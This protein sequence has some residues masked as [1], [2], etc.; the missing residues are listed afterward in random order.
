MA[1]K[2]LAKLIHI[3]AAGLVSEVVI[4]LVTGKTSLYLGSFLNYLLNCGNHL[5]EK[6]TL[7]MAHTYTYTHSFAI[8][9]WQMPFTFTVFLCG[10]K[11]F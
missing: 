11:P 2:I 3:C 7:H 9:K 8:Y 4:F 10:P 1:Q 5:I 6:E